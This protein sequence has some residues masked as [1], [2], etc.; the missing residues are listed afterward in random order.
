VRAL[1]WG[2]HDPQQPI[3]TLTL[4]SGNSAG[5]LVVLAVTGL[6]PAR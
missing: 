5:G 1:V 6:G 3:R 4:R 2:G